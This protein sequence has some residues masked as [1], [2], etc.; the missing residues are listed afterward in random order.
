MERT[1]HFLVNTLALKRGGLVKAVRERAN[2]LAAAGAG[3]GDVNIVVLAAQSRLELDVAA[4][5]RD[6]HLHPRVGVYSILQTLDPSTTDAREPYQLDE[7]PGITVFPVGRTGREF[8]YFRDGLFEKH[9]RFDEDGRVVVV[10]HF[11]AAHHRYR[12]EEMDETGSVARALEYHPGTGE[13]VSQR[14]FGR[15]SGCYLTI[16]HHQDDATWGTSFLHGDEQRSFTTMGGLYRHA[17]ERALAREPAPAIVS[18]FRENLRNLPE[19]NVDDIVRSIRHPNVLKVMTSHSNHLNEPY[20]TGATISPNWT[21]AGENLDYWDRLVVQTDAQKADMAHEY[22]HGELMRVIG[23]VAP[24]ESSTPVEVDPY[25]V[26]IVARIHPKKRLDEAMRAFAHVVQAEP[27]AR[28]EVFGFGYKDA[29]E[30]RLTELIAELGLVDHVRFAPFTN[31]PAQIYASALV[32]MLTSASEGFPLTLLESMSH[33]VPVAAYDANYGPRDVIEDG[34]NGF[35]VPFGEHDVLAKRILGLM[36]DPD[37]RARM[38]VAARATLAR[39][40][41]EKF[42]RRWV[43]VLSAD[44]RPARMTGASIGPIISAVEEDGS[45]SLRFVGNGPMPAGLE[46]VLIARAT[47]EIIA[48]GAHRHDVWTFALGPVPTGTIADVFASTD[49]GT[50]RRRVPAGDV[51]ATRAAGWRVYRTPRGALSL[52]CL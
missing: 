11:D 32:T 22:G 19:E 52:K 5:K 46:L 34:V 51:T 44:P 16:W 29:E 35:L 41:R 18:E 6:G 15:D 45:G 25:R 3:E 26:I 13:V 30:S 33:G 48:R 1:A 14:Y 21:R 39:F 47:G 31:D 49:G 28:L 38:D 27:R 10:E 12:R 4:L 20:V 50:T 7:G 36:R 17:F 2:A 24:P 8:R 43:E 42:V 37:A 9:A 23:Q 40:S